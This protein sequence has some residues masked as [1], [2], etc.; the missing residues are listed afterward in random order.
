MAAVISLCPESERGVKI[1]DELETRTEMKPMEVIDDKTRRYY[2]EAEDATVDAFDPMLDQ[3]DR[4]WRQHVNNRTD[5]LESEL[6]EEL[7]QEELDEAWEEA[8]ED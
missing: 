2:L 3:I 5:Q 1:L 7:D 8:G 6:D 4:D